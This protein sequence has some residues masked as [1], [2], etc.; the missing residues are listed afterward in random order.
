[1]R[2][3]ASEAERAFRATYPALADL[4]ITASWA[5]PVDRTVSGLPFF[6]PLGGREEILY[7]V[8]FSGNGVGPARVGARILAGRRPEPLTARLAHLAPAARGK[9][10]LDV[11][12]GAP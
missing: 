8:G 6:S 7:G 11:P 4:P 12:S 10:R 9:A 3:R 2:P 1:M 5:G